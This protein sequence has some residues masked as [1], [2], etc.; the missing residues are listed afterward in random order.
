MKYLFLTLSVL[1]LCE[2]ANVDVFFLSGQSN[3]SGRAN[4]GYVADARDAS[5]NYYY[6]TDGP[7]G[8]YATSGSFTSL[9]PVSTGYYGSEIAIGRQLVS[10]GYTNPYLIKIARGGMSIGSTSQ[11]GVSDSTTSMWSIW[12][13]SVSAALE[14]IIANGDTPVLRAFFWN[15]GE[16]DAPVTAY[17]ESYEANFSYLVD[18]IYGHLSSYD[19]ADMQFVT[20]LTH[21][22]YGAGDLA[23]YGDVESV[24]DGQMSVMNSD[25]RYSYFDTNDI[26]EDT[27]LMLDVL[28][29]SGEGL[30]MIGERFVSSYTTS[31]PEPQAGLFLLLG[32]GVVLLRRRH[33]SKG[34]DL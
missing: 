29:F 32:S 34:E 2:A 30:D 22:T 3:A 17:A 13:E 11:W 7:V 21:N 23:F 15:Q 33:Y 19:S 18:S 31:V 27:G 5:V 26:S 16:S 20:A 9:S 24:R 25:A 1:G 4:T 6:D 8:V 28:H 10:A 14:T 12:K